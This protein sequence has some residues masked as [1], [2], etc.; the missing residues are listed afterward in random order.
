MLAVFGCGRAERHEL[1]ATLAAV[2]RLRDADTP[3]RPAALEALSAVTTSG[4]EAT[5]ARSACLDAYRAL[6]AT[7]RL[8]AEAKGPPV[9]RAKLDAAERSLREARGGLESC[10]AA[11]TALRRRLAR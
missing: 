7:N 10:Q 3:L 4:P 8:V 9:D 1:E 5:R 2:E 11:T 6:D